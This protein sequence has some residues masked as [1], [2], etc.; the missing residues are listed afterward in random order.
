[1][2]KAT[3]VISGSASQDTSPPDTLAFYCDV[4]R[5]LN[6]HSLPYLVGGAYAFNHYSGINRK[7]EDFDIFIA[8]ADYDRISQALA[9]EG[10]TTELTYPHWL[11]KVRCNGNVI[12]LIFSSGNGIANVDKAWFDHATSATILGVPTRLCPPE[13]MI[14]SKAYIMEKERFDGADIAH[15]I[16]ACGKQLDWQRLLARF[17]PHWRLLLSHLTLFGFIYPTHRDVVPTWLMEHLV[18]LLKSDTREP[19]PTDNICGGTLLSR[20]QYLNDID[21]GGYKDARIEPLG[22]MSEQDTALWTKA[23]AR[24]WDDT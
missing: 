4:L 7:T 5:S 23:I 8:H 24:K 15:L 6:Q 16:L 17:E 3:A 19:L 9:R 1:M 12:D 14:W 2:Q 13:E 22:N 21:K 10:Y 11:G 20:E 18:D